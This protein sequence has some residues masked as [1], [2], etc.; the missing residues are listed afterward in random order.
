MQDKAHTI[1]VLQETVTKT[2]VSLESLKRTSTQ[3]CKRKLVQQKETYDAVI[4]RHL[5]FIDQL[6]ADKTALNDKVDNL[7]ESL[8]TVESA[9]ESRLRAA[10]ERAAVDMKRA[11][12]GWA[13]AEK[14]RR[15]ALVRKLEK[16]IKAD[17]AKALEPEVQRILDRQRAEMERLK[18]ELEARLTRERADIAAR[19][20]TPASSPASHGKQC[21]ALTS[22]LLHARG[23]AS[24]SRA[25]GGHKK[26]KI[27]FDGSKT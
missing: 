25:R 19:H 10:R 5:S 18:E 4:Q 12:D 21:S 22:P 15:D 8:K 3:E 14:A 20:A 27:F 17:T 6:L 11:Q 26:H 7:T 24:P 1:S 2:R 13:S 9:W 16:E 23:C